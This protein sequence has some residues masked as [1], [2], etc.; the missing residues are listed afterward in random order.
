MF[1]FGVYILGLLSGRLLQKLEVNDPRAGDADLVGAAW[2][3]RGH[4]VR[5]GPGRT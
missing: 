5:G 3:S 2:C 1:G 4:Q